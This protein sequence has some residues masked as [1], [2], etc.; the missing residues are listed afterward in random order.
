M[1]VIRRSTLRRRGQYSGINRAT[2]GELIALNVI[3]K[4]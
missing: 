2:A 1:I 4:E 3:G